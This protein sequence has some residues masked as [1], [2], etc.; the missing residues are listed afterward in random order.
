MRAALDKN[1]LIRVYNRI[2]ARYDLQH[3]F[4]TAGADGRGRRLVVKHAVHKNDSVLDAGAGSTA[5]LAAQEAGTNGRV[6]L[7][8]MNEPLA[9][10]MSGNPTSAHF[11][12]GISVHG[13]TMHLIPPRKWTQSGIAAHPPRV[14]QVALNETML[15]E[16]KKKAE[17]ASLSDRLTFKTGDLE[18]LPFEDHTFDAVLSTYSLCPLFDPEKGALELY[19]VTRPGGRIGIAHSVEPEG[20]MLKWLADKV[21]NIAWRIPS[22]SMGCRAVSTLPALKEAGACVLFERRLGIP[23]WP[24]IVFVLK[25][26]C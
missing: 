10:L 9:K 5:L 20:R 22:L 2:S 4:I 23:L 12:S 24:F 8:D 14:L 11:R 15:S 26:P 3:A 21:E 25:K 6:T 18:H 1:L 13:T 17:K 19:R 16:A 7:L